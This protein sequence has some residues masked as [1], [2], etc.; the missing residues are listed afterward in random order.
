MPFVLDASVT[1]CW[2]FR[3]E[4]H[5]VADFARDHLL[6]E[7]AVV[8]SLWWFE[9]RNL[10]VVN[11]RRGRLSEADSARFLRILGRLGIAQDLA[12]EESEVL[13]LARTYR[14]SVYDAAY[15]ELAA[16]NRIGLATLDS[17]LARA[18]KQESVALVGL[19]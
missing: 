8:P 5:P 15:L 4:E 11:E 9:I 7:E 13:R 16:R 3:D 2:A 12:P 6:N 19:A 10:L 17:A 14:L 18:A 1:A